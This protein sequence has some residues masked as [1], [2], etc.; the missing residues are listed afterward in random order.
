MFFLCPYRYKNDLERYQQSFNAADMSVCVTPQK[1]FTV[2]FTPVKL[3]DSKYEEL[4]ENYQKEVEERKK[5]EAELKLLQIKL[6]NQP[7][8][9]PAPSTMNHRDIARHQ[10][11]SSVFSWQ[12]ERTPSRVSSGNHDVSGLKRN[13]TAI[14][15]PWEQEETPSKRG[16]KSD[17]GNHRSFCESANNPAND[18]LR[19]QNQELRSK[20]N[21]LELRF[22]VQEKELKNQL[23]KLQEAQTVLDKTQA[24]LSDRDKTLAKCRDDLARM[25]GQYEQSV[26]KVRKSNS[27]DL[28]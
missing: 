18:L 7:T 27:G 24:A 13:Y 20:V 6:M 1:S 9:P 25:T 5:L 23:H 28:C 21:D 8:Q 11:S 22:Q 17:G 26:D 15:Y 10:S 4:Q 16:F 19:N 12:Q 2:S 14:Q 3:N